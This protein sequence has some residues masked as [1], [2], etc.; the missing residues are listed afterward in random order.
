MVDDLP[1]A[2]DHPNAPIS[3]AELI[4]DSHSV[5]DAANRLF[6]DVVSLMKPIKH[7][8]RPM[9]RRSLF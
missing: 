7:D 8:V 2:V 4:G 6:T 5:V 1:V 3:D 9:T